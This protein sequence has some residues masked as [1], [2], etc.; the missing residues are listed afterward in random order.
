MS[1]TGKFTASTPAEREALI[2][3]EGVVALSDKEAGN[4]VGGRAE[5]PVKCPYCGNT[6]VEKIPLKPVSNYFCKPCQKV[7]AA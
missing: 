3:T 6:N 1:N 5:E 2:Q 7:F 4:V